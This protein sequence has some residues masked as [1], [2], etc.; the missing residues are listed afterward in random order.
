[1]GF[2]DKRMFPLQQKIY[3]SL[4][5]LETL[6][7]RYQQPL[8]TFQAVRDDT[9][10][11]KMRVPLVGAFSAGKSTLLNKL[12]GEDLLS[13]EVSPET[14][15]ATELHYAST[16]QIIGHYKNGQL[17]NLSRQTLLEQSFGTLIPDG[18]IELNTP[19]KALLLF[20]HLCLVDMPGLDSGLSSHVR[21]IDNYIGCSLAYIVIVSVED[22]DLHETTRQFL[23]ELALHQ[24]PVLVVISKC[25]KRPRSDVEQVKTAIKQTIQKLLA[26]RPFQIVET[27]ARKREIS[28]FIEALV[29]LEGK[30]EYQFQQTVGQRFIKILIELEKQ[31][32]TLSNQ[33]DLNTEQ[34]E[35]K[36]SQLQTELQAFKTRLSQETL[37]IERQIDPASSRILSIVENA[38]RAKAEQLATHIVDG[39][40]INS[41][42]TAIIRQAVTTGIHQEF[43]LKI[44]RY[45]AKI[46]MELPQ[47]IQIGG[48]D[49]SKIEVSKL[50]T[51]IIPGAL[52][53]LASVLFKLHPVMAMLAP[54]LSGILGIFINQARQESMAHQ[55]REA[56]IQHVLTTVIPQVLQQL[57]GSLHTHLQQYVAQAQQHITR[58]VET[59]V[60]QHESAL[61]RLETEL[62]SGQEAFARNRVVY[63]NDLKDVQRMLTN[64]KGF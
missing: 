18:W 19:S 17:I 41:T 53:S 16:E 22:G 29:Q 39:G 59:R 56:A 4:P 26:N 30:S 11:F 44:E 45:V 57:A 31:L 14:S 58:E 27:S 38:L 62:K 28:A 10:H 61:K 24:M 64:L 3:D 9:T 40:S 42:I 35:V 7:I 5:L 33:D 54:I 50:P 8:E 15:L 63:L 48:F 55:R 13:V 49:G 46:E 37:Q 25:E 23:T 6:L 12:L 32:S 43:S 1:M 20:P 51:E 52:V 47:S 36:K 34:I 2:K 60:T 21:A